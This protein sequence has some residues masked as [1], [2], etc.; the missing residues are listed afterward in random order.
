MGEEINAK[1]PYGALDISARE[2][3]MGSKCFQELWDG[4]HYRMRPED[5]ERMKKY[6]KQIARAMKN[7]KVTLKLFEG[8][9]PK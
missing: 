4:G 2:M 9:V 3:E 5:I 8:V 6:L 1:V 7:T